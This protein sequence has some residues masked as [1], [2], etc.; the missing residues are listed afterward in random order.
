MPRMC[1][2][3]NLLKRFFVIL[4]KPSSVSHPR[5]VGLRKACPRLEDIYK[6]QC[7]MGGTLTQNQLIAL[8]I[9]KI[10][11][12]QISIVPI[13]VSSDWIRRS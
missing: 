8:G 12:E 3:G 13:E 11:A 10:P 4:Y 9:Q 5:S 7:E 1:Q 6:D 2:K